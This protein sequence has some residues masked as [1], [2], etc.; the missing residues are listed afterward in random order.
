MLQRLSLVR[1]SW[2]RKQQQHQQLLQQRR[3]L[4]AEAPGVLEEGQPPQAA[5]TTPLPAP[6]EA[7]AAPQLRRQLATLQDDW[8]AWS[9]VV[10]EQGS[11]FSASDLVD[12]VV[13]L[14]IEAAR[15]SQLLRPASPHQAGQQRGGQQQQ[16]GGHQQEGQVQGD[17]Q[18][19]LLRQLWQQ[20]VQLA[21][22]PGMAEQL[23][24]WQWSQLLYAA[25]KL[26]RTRADPALLAAAAQRMPPAMHAMH[27]AALAN[28]VWAYAAAAADPGEAW[29]AAWTAAAAA[30][31]P[32]L[33]AHQLASCLWAVGALG[34]R[35]PPAFLQRLLTCASVAM[36]RLGPS[37]LTNALWALSRLRYLPSRRWLLRWSW[38]A[39]AAMA[40]DALAPHHLAG[41]LA[42]LAL[43]RKQP[44]PRWR[45]AWRGSVRRQ[46]GRFTGRQ[47]CLCLCAAGK[48]RWALGEHWVLLLAGRL[49]EVLPQCSTSDL[50]AALW[51]LPRVAYPS[52]RRAGVALAPLL[53]RAVG[54][55]EPQLGRCSP[56][57]LTQ[58]AV[59]LAALGHDPGVHWLK[60]HE[61]ACS[62]QV[63]GFSP[64]NRERLRN[65]Y[66]RIW[67]VHR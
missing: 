44:H 15:S 63:A 7:G 18:Q 59:G 49:G 65:S 11:A 14:R 37:E 6:A 45:K 42:S 24:P 17:Q 40:R 27:G 60:L 47:V 51:A 25:V 46:L 1:I 41:Q 54:Q 29:L 22:A 4:A 55:L 34:Y 38:F 32:S 67:G 57:Q 31:L 39:S 16:Q 9:A 8:G 53:Q 23:R 19:Q 20:V 13:R 62:A 35:A 66:L 28:S 52:P 61:N 26:A 33:N 3:Q 56:A 36:G 43:L 50:A 5:A 58:L 30:H 12:C 64:E 21:L 10:A 2:W 48:L